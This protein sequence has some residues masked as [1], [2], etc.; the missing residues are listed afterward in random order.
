M[1]RP[2]IGGQGAGNEAD[3]RGLARAVRADERVDL[4]GAHLEAR[5]VDRDYAAEALTEVA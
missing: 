2:P 1:D 3:Q 4:A 5:A